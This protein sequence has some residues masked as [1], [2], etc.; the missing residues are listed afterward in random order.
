MTPSYLL[1]PRALPTLN[2][3]I[4]P[5][6]CMITYAHEWKAALVTVRRRQRFSSAA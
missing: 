5:A 2:S 1:C 4:R 6:D 3:M